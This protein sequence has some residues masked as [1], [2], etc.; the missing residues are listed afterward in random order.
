MDLEGGSP[1]AIDVGQYCREI[2]TYLCRKNDGHLI[3][4]VGPAFE[5]VSGWAERGIPLR[6][7]FEG[8]DRFF[9]RYYR[10][11][12]RRRPVHISFCDADVLDAF[13]EWRR[14]TGV[15]AG[16]AEAVGVSEP[17]KRTR[18]SLNRHLERTIAALTV[19]RSGSPAALEAALERIVRELDRLRAGGKPLRGQARVEA[20]AKLRELDARLSAEAR[21]ALSREQAEALE[22]EAEQSL[23][24]FRERMTGEA[25]QSA[26][27][28]AIDRSVRAALRLPVIACDD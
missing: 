19:R 5:L 26:R 24:P 14:A 17:S 27:A 3:R 10:K 1:A 20:L 18:P 21:A 23:A 13:D 22:R 25:W 4:I 28:A 6:V 9:E 16:A 11:G 12:P 7:A 2:E 15:P 8:I